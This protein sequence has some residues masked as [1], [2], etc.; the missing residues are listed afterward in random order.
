MTLVTDSQIGESKDSS[1][2]GIKHDGIYPEK[3][4]CRI[5]FE[6]D[7][8]TNPLM[9]PCNCKGSVKY[10]HQECL[11]RWII[12]LNKN[13]GKYL[14]DI[15]KSP[16]N[17]K[18]KSKLILSCKNLKYEIVKILS[19]PFVFL[20]VTGMIYLIIIFF[21]QKKI[22]PKV[23]FMN[24]VFIA[25]FMVSLIMID[26][27]AIFTCINSIRVGFF[28]VEI[29]AFVGLSKEDKKKDEVECDNSNET[30]LQINEKGESVKDSEDREGLD[31][32]YEI[33][34]ESGNRS[35][36]Y[37]VNTDC[38]SPGLARKEE[39]DIKG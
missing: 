1:F 8:Q 35:R 4:Q 22:N 14:C 20:A 26:I 27:I 18:I 10:I 38:Q 32:K 16:L 13:P 31:V 3:K 23:T 37:S 33:L 11:R 9:A 24:K 12:I 15:C 19:F 39:V 25:L 2:L 30:I 34:D 7:T 36:I 5:C 6:N 21:S 28:R 29:L 17:V